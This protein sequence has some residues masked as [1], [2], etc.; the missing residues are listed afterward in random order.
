MERWRWRAECLRMEPPP[1][2]LP[3]S[4]DLFQSS[5]SFSAKNKCL[6]L[7][8][9]LFGFRFQELVLVIHFPDRLQSPS[10]HTHFFPGKYFYDAVKSSPIS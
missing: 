8:L 5:V 6:T 7:Y 1:C 2:P 4:W 9:S 3:G 10:A